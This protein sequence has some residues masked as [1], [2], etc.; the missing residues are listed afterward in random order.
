MRPQDPRLRRAVWISL[1]VAL[2]LSVILAALSSAGHLH[3]IDFRWRPLSLIAGLLGMAVFL[4]A[5]VEIWRMQLGFLGARLDRRSATAVW[6]TSALGRYVPTGMMMPMMRVALAEPLGVPKRVSLASFI[7]ETALVLTAGLIIGAYSILSLPQAQ[8]NVLRYAVLALPLLALVAMHPRIFHPLADSA[9]KK[10]GRD[11]L[12]SSLGQGQLVLI[13]AC[14]L[15]DLVIAGLATYELAQLITPL[16]SGDLLT[17]IGAFAASLVLSYVAF[18]L[19]G[20]L[21]ARE[22]G[23]ALLLSAVMPTAAAVGVA[24][25]S[26]VAQILVEVATTLVAQVLVRR[27]PATGP[28]R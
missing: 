27:A 13:L 8:D 1:A 28:A 19:P 22:A 17:V 9:L 11:P 20:G 18:L 10:L 5:A 23:M 15:A 4:L 26:R 12:P 2:T 21:G 25:I 14:Y 3:G 16:D 24:L 7:Y 6:F